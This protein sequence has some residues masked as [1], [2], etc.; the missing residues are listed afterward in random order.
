VSKV[1]TANELALN[2]ELRER[3]PVGEELYAL[4]DVGLSEDVAAAELHAEVVQHSADLVGE[5]TLG[6]IGDALEEV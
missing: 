1:R 4:A 6:G 5:T 2:V 3:G